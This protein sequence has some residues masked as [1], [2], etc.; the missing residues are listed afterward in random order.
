MLRLLGRWMLKS[1]K[2]F[3][4]IIGHG[5]VNSSVLVIPVQMNATEDFAIMG[6]CYI[7]VLLEAVDEV[8]GVGLTD[9]F[10]TEI[11]DGEIESCGTRDVVEESGSMAGWNI[12]IGSKMF[13]E[14]DVCKSSGLRKAVHAGA[15]L[16]KE[17][18]VFD[19]GTKFVFLHDIVGDGPFEVVEIFVLAGV[20]KR[21]D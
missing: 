5:E 8:I 19:E 21:C 1:R 11:V 6:D 15:D 7:V 4:D 3:G 14:L 16:G 2:G 10:D 18:F 9:N 17:L 20:R 13:D 12:T